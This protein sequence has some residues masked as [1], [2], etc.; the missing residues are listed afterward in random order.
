M[1]RASVV[2]RA[3]RYFAEVARDEALP[4]KPAPFPTTVPLRSVPVAALSRSYGLL[5]AV[6]NIA[7]PVKEHVEHKLLKRQQASKREQFSGW[8]L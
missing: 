3:V 6:S 7:H 5:I 4:L 2:I 1:L 8:L